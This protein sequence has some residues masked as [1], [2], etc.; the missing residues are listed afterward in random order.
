[1]SHQ[2]VVTKD[3]ENHFSRID[4]ISGIP[5]LGGGRV[6]LIVDMSDLVRSLRVPKAAWAQLQSTGPAGGP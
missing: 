2:Q 3:I 1:M 5:I 6:A 4:S